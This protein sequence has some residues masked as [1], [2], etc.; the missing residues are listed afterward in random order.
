[1]ASQHLLRWL[2][3]AAA[4]LPSTTGAADEVDDGEE[5]AGEPAAKRRRRAYDPSKPE[6][7]AGAGQALV[8]GATKQQLLQVVPTVLDGS[9]TVEDVSHGQQR[10]V[11]GGMRLCLLG[12][13]AAAGKPCLQLCSLLEY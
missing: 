4:G 13:G 6:V 8:P 3:P 9:A 2:L 12:C 1:M 7:Q 11:P 5:V 10:L